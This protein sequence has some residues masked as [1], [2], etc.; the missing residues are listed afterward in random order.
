MMVVTLV[1]LMFASLAWPQTPGYTIRQ[2]TYPKSVETWALAINDNKAARGD[3]I[4][5]FASENDGGEFAKWGSAYVKIPDLF[6]A[7]SHINGLNNHRAIIGNTCDEEGYVGFYHVGASKNHREIRTDIIRYPGGTYTTIFGVNDAGDIVGVTFAGDVAGGNG[8]HTA[9]VLEDDTY[10]PLPPVDGW[11]VWPADINNKGLIVGTVFRAD[12]WQHYGFV[13]D[14]EYEFFTPEEGVTMHV[15]GVNDHGHIVGWTGFYE[16]ND[17]GVFCCHRSFL[18]KDS[19][20]TTINATK[21]AQTVARGIN[22]AGHIV[23]TFY[24]PVDDWL[25]HGF[26]AVPKPAKVVKR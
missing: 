4:G 7:Q 1:F 26:V 23:G 22:N 13:Y 12:T 20:F 5:R 8:V 10:T 17:D 2:I 24:R 19:T 25:A 18:F 14:G 6:C 11:E 9:F 16:E 15:T 3:V 21:D